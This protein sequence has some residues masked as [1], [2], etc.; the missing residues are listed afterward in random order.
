VHMGAGWQN[1][2]PEA[3]EEDIARERERQL[4]SLV[5][6]ERIS[7]TALPRRHRIARLLA[8]AARTALK[9]LP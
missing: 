5:E 1:P 7:E 4:V 6:R 8:K 2:R 3:A 9:L